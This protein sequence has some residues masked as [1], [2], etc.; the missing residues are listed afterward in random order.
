MRLMRFVC[1]FAWA[2]LEIRPEE[3]EFVHAMIERL[4]LDDE[5]REAVRGWLDLPPEPESIDPTLVPRA[6][7][8]VVIEAIGGIIAADGRIAPEEYESFRIFQDLVT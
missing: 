5:E 3:R 6:H 8:R 1:S 4:T 7:R 2:D